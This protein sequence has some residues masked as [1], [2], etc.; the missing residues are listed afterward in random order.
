MIELFA[1]ALRSAAALDVINR[2]H[3]SS[4]ARVEPRCTPPPRPA[5]PLCD[6]GAVF[7]TRSM[8]T[9]S[10]EPPSA[11]GAPGGP[12]TESSASL[13]VLERTEEQRSPGDEER[14][15]HYVR[16][17]RITESAV[18]GQPVVALCGKIWTPTRNP[19]R[20][21]VCPTCKAIYEQIG[22]G[23]GEWP[24]GPNVP[25]SNS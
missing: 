16:K 14:Y 6:V 4:H 19:D 1:T 15:A 11:P 22:G 5:T 13:D 20:F 9:S 25:G 8:S 2:L 12:E 7:Y 17:E 24:F 3:R 18:L 10:P 21:P 23:K